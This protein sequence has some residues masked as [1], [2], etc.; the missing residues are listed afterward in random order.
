[1]RRSGNGE[2]AKSSLSRASAGRGS[3]PNGP[4]LSTS[5]NELVAGFVGNSQGLRNQAKLAKFLLKAAALN[6]KN[7][8]KNNLLSFI[9]PKAGGRHTFLIRV[10]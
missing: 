2:L 7:L 4:K 6:V 3:A 5:S 9:K 10:S 8:I 1:M